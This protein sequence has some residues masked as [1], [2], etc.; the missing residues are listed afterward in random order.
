MKSGSPLFI[1]PYSK[2]LNQN[3]KEHLEVALSGFFEKWNAH[4]EPLSAKMW[5]E[6][7]QFLLI[8]VDEAQAQASG[9]SKDRLFHFI[10]EINSIHDLKEGPVGKFYVRNKG[11]IG[12]FSRNEIREGLKEGTI[13]PDNE[14]YPVWI[15]STEQYEQF[16][17]KP[18]RTF[19]QLLK[20]N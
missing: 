9:C 12:V 1:F 8:Y 20:L 11:Q 19:G 7:E 4:G 6:E 2:G 13:L 15:N 16:W 5:I 17:K 18:V 10:N 3:Q 14:L